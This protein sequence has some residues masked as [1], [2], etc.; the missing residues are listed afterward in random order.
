[1]KKTLLA[2]AVS[3]AAFTGA[4]NAAE[5]YKTDDAS[6][7]FYGQLRTELKFL[8]GEDAKLG[9]GSSR[10]GV[11][12]KYQVNDSLGVYG[13]VELGIQDNKDVFVRKHI[14]GL[15]TNYGA[16]EFGKALTLSDD[17]YGAEYS[18]FFGGTGLF[19]GTLNGAFHDSQ[20]RY[21][22]DTDSFWLK[23]AYGLSEDDSNDELA[24]LFVGTSFGDLALH[25]GGGID[26][27]TNYMPGDEITN[28][29]AEATAEY[30]YGKGIVGFT[31]YYQNLDSKVLDTSIDGNAFNFSGTYKWLDNATAYAGV[32]Y[33]IY[34]ADNHDD[35]DGTNIYVGTDYFL[36]SWA[37][38]YVEGAY[39]DGSTLGYASDQTG[40]SVGPTTVDSE[41]NFGIGA[42]VYW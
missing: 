19:Y 8:D 28:T 1:M 29:Y 12:A 39:Q 9:T 24:E 23:A 16:V 34:S 41:F 18:Y 33:V 35:E 20:I 7:D 5:I 31:Y 38:V 26:K 4:A 13:S 6:V 10:T 32:E 21:K 40:V 3:A 2:L 42:R 25:A 36:T 22:L 37:R 27:D 11:D 17:V 14:F 15:D 30:S